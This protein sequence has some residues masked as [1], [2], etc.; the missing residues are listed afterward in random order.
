[1]RILH[2]ASILASAAAFAPQH[3]G[4]SR[5]VSVDAS[6]QD[7][8]DRILGAKQETV[9]SVAVEEEVEPVQSKKKT[10]SDAMKKADKWISD[11]FNNFEP[12][13]GHGTGH[14]ELKE[15][16][17]DQK[18]V[19]AKRKSHVEKEYLKEKYKDIGV[20]HHGEIPMIAFDPADLNK[21][22]D[23]AMY[24]DEDYSIEVPS[25]HI[26]EAA[27]KVAEKMTNW[28]GIKSNKNLSPWESTPWT[29]T[30]LPETHNIKIIQSKD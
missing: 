15:I 4:L 27:D 21:K 19:L 20:D 9:E 5:Q 8:F 10:T 16:R 22:E 29:N 17:K 1:M 28:L 26:E 3:A 30:V 12:I 7:Y 25:F 2:F 23:D 14:T 11:V 6:I 24:V 13:H 18:E